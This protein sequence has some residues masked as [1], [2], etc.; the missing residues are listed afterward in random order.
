MHQNSYTFSTY[1]YKQENT[2]QIASAAV[3]TFG[4]DLLS[5]LEQGE[6]SAMF[7]FPVFLLDQSAEL[8]STLKRFISKL[9]YS[10]YSPPNGFTFQNF[11]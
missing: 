10:K 3:I 11:N 1:C 4:I 8:S 9:Q 2:A 6:T 7:L 5:E